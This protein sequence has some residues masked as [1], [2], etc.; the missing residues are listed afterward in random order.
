MIDTASNTVVAT[1]PVE[2]NPIGVAVT[3]D[4]K[5]VYVTNKSS[6]GILQSPRTVGANSAAVEA[7][8]NTTLAD[9]PIAAHSADAAATDPPYVAAA[10]APRSRTRLTNLATPD[11]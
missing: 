7:L 5:H 8:T 6:N 3:P 4:G 1:V 2:N 10:P 11:E 9:G